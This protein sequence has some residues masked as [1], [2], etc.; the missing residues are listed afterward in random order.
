MVFRLICQ[1]QNTY[2]LVQ[3][4]YVYYMEKM[5][6]HNVC[7]DMYSYQLLARGKMLYLEQDGPVILT[8]SCY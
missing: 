8:K 1:Q 3:P 2:I 5:T 6:P 7:V 4:Y